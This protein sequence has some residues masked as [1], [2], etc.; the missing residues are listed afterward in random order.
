MA[1]LIEPDSGSAIHPRGLDEPKT[2]WGLVKTVRHAFQN[3]FAS[4]IRPERLAI[5]CRPH[6]GDYSNLTSTQSEDAH[7]RAIATT[8]PDAGSGILPPLPSSTLWRSKQRW[9]LRALAA[10]PLFLIADEPTTMLD[11]SLKHMMSIDYFANSPMILDSEYSWSYDLLG[12]RSYTDRITVLDHG[13]VIAT[14][15]QNIFLTK[16][17]TPGAAQLIRSS[18]FLTRKRSHL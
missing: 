8:R 5:P 3:P 14:R 10:E 11:Q 17:E 13:S 2:L 9:F 15:R 7:S 12:A 16:I 1:W 6:F 4:S 18:H